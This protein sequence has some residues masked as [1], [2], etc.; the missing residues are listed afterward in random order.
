MQEALA[1]LWALV[2]NNPRLLSTITACNMEAPKASQCSSNH[3]QDWSA[4]LVS[5]LAPLYL[6]WRL[7]QHVTAL[8]SAGPLRFYYYYYTLFLPRGK[9][10]L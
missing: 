6:A 7:L 2:L 9:V 5:V 1:F 8:S 10:H 4:I 3:S